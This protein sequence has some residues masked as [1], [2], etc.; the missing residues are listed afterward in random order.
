[1]ATWNLVNADN[2]RL[3]KTALGIPAVYVE[4]YR[5]GVRTDNE[6]VAAAFVA[7]QAGGTIMFG[8]GVTY[9]LTETADLDLT[10]KPNVLLNGHGATL[11]M[12]TNGGRVLEAHGTMGSSTTLTAA[13]TARAYTL[14]V[15]SSSAF[16]VGDLVQITSD[17]EVFNADHVTG[18]FKS[19][20]GRVSAVPD[21]TTITL[22][23][24]TWDTYSITGPTVT[25]QQYTPMRN[26]KIRDL[27]VIG[28]NVAGVSGAQTGINVRYFDGVEIHNVRVDDSGNM[29]VGGQEGINFTVTNSRA[30]NTLGV[31]GYGFHSQMVVTTKFVNCYGRL[32][33]HTADA[34]NTKDLLIQGCTAE[35]DTS[36]GIS[37]HGS[38]DVVKVLDNTVHE[39]GGGITVRGRN[40]VVRGNHVMGGRGEVNSDNY[41]HGILVGQGSSFDGIAGTNLIIEGN[42]IDMQC[43]DWDSSIEHDG[44]WIAAPL[45]DAKILNNIIKGFQL[46]GLNAIGDYNTNAEI[47]GNTFDCS[48]LNGTS[49]EFGIRIRPNDRVAANVSTNL[50]IERNRIVNGDPHY[51]IFVDGG[52]TTSPRTDNVRIRWNEI[53]ACQTSPIGLMDGYYGSDAVVYGNRTA[54][55]KAV[56]LVNANWTKPPYIGQHGYGGNAKPLGVGQELGARMRR[57]RAY[58]P[59]GYTVGGVTTTLNRLYAVPLFVPRR[60]ALDRIGVNVTTGSGTG[61]SLGLLG[62]YADSTDEGGAPGV[63]VSGSTGSVATDASGYVEATISVTLTPGLYWLAFVTQTAAAFVTVVQGASQV[64]GVVGT[65]ASAHNRTGFYGDSVS[66]ALPDPYPATTTT[67]SCPWVQVHVASTSVL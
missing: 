47:V 45:V 9:V 44:I 58:G 35:H 13:I 30:N 20:M 40:N 62:I 37:V 21:G 39:C 18:Q 1:M 36:A 59:T 53:A 50:T 31:N 51:G 2:P 56:S 34:H 27:T 8:E 48:S 3:A 42:V 66:G 11:S 54:D 6:I 4:D 15:A 16:S 24:R 7:L 55:T 29:G 67:S 41:R 10:G 17:S 33:R 5:D 65:G 14:T 46:Y 64:V 38:T 60:V 28:S 57:S 23:S 12:A 61:G 19:E 49:S 43:P 63:L 52:T 32:N 26:L 25:V 22:D